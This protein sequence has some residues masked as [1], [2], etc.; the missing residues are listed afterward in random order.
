MSTPAALHSK[1]KTD[2]GTP[3]EVVEGARK[4]MGS[5]D[6]DL[7]SSWYWNHHVV[8]AAR[9][10]S[11]G[12]SAL[13]G[14]TNPFP[15]G[16]YLCNP[17]GGLVVEFWDL[18]RDL[19]VLGSTVFWVGFS[20]EQMAYLQ[21]RE[22]FSAAF[23]RTIPRRR[24]K[25]LERHGFLDR[26]RHNSPPVPAARPSHSNFLVLMRDSYSIPDTRMTPRFHDLASS[27][28]GKVF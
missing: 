23:L 21:D 25:F 27:L 22:L 11:E 12:E 24:L 6:Y 3:V 10:W 4:V 16:N 8:H 1:E 9:F 26:K 20:V 2:W 5:I 28:G 17:T 19:V 15:R 7:C 14:T 18:C 13:D